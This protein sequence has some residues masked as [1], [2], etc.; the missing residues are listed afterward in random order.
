M[1]YI[2]VPEFARLNSMLRFNSGESKVCGRLEAYSCKQAGYDKKLAKTID[3][4]ISDTLATSPETYITSPFGSLSNSSNRKLFLYFISTLNSSFPDYDFS[5]LR[6]EQIQKE[7]SLRTVANTIN[8]TLAEA[9]E[10]E[11]Q[12]LC[13]QLW[14]TLYD[15]INPEECEIYSYVPDLD[16]DPL[17]D[18]KIW[19]FNYFFYNK[20]LRKVVFFTCFSKRTYGLDF[21]A[22][23]CDEDDLGSENGAPS[24]SS[25]DFRETMDD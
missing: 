12:T 16:S 25:E 14:M 2:D 15:A 1:K 4:N 8:A 9:F 7:C 19:S 6:P 11:G 21:D 23:S 22:S 5:N 3:Q 18:G 20:K 24:D 17:S 10:H 13:D